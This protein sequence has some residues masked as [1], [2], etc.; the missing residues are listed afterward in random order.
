VPSP[1]KSRFLNA[2]VSELKACAAR[3]AAA[4]LDFRKPLLE[5]SDM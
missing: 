3:A 2:G 4:I 1:I 5:T